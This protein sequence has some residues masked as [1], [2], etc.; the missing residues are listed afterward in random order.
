MTAVARALHIFGA[1]VWVG[2]MFAIYVCLRPALGTLEPPQRLQLMRVTFQKFF[3]WVWVAILLLLVSGYW[4]M[5]TTFGGFAGAGLYIHL[6]QMIGWLMIALFVWLFHGPSSAP[7]GATGANSSVGLLLTEFRSGSDSV[8][9]RC[10]S[11]DR[12]STRSGISSTKRSTTVRDG[13]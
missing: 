8:L 1:V 3:P 11:H 6:M 10:S 2:G 9:K 7:V 12:P 4:M 5:F 13:C